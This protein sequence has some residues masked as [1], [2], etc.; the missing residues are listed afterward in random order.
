M[1]ADALS[2]ISTSAHQQL[3]LNYFKRTTHLQL[4]SMFLCCPLIWLFTQPSVNGSKKLSVMCGGA[5]FSIL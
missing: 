2:Y 1:W 5:G 3:S 4:Y